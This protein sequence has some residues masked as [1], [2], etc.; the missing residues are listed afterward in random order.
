MIFADKVYRKIGPPCQKPGDEVA[1]MFA[2]LARLFV[3]HL[4]YIVD[5][6]NLNQTFIHLVNNSTQILNTKYVVVYI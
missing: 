5:K 4:A 1:I 3:A 6:L 2:N